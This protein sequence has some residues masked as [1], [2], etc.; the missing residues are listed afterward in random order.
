M[1]LTNMT[2]HTHKQVLR[3]LHTP[4]I[5]KLID[6]HEQVAACFDEFNE[7]KNR[8]MHSN[9]LVSIYFVLN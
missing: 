1:S 2:S 4:L 9:P 3:T 7:K 8:K 6:E 5:I